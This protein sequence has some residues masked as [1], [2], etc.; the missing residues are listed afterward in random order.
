M[1]F[2]L[3]SFSATWEHNFRI[4]FYYCVPNFVILGIIKIMKVVSMGENTNENNVQ[5]TI[6]KT[7]IDIPEEN[8]LFSKKIMY[9]DYT[10]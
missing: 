8:H 3:R 7:F 2:P 4:V 1:F 5:Y 6:E 9:E 10:E